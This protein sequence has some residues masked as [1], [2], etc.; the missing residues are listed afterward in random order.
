MSLL[1]LSID[2]ETI[3]LP[4]GTETDN[5]LKVKEIKVDGKVI[6]EKFSKSEK[7]SKNTKIEIYYYS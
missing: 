2:V 1:Y 7:F 6:N 4:R 3:S 5:P